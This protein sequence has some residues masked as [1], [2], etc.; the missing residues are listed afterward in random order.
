MNDGLLSRLQIIILAAGFSSRLGEPKALARVHATSLLRRALTIAA[1]LN[2]SRIL[3]IV[4]RNAAR[5]RIEAGGLN[6]DFSINPHPQQGLSSS[7][8]RGVA[9]AR[10][11]AAIF[12]LPVDLVNL[13]RRDVA[14][15]IS[16]WRGA[17]RCVIARRVALHGGSPLILPRWLFARALGLTG[18][19]G[20]RDLT[21]RLPRDVV[22]LADLPSAQL[23]IDTQ[24]DLRSARRR[25]RPRG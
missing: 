6:V 13:R 16:R 5:Y 9:K 22:R 7:V 3:A 11:A 18:D 8:R 17:R 19:V 1:S 4:P 14:R 23:D 24:Q 2:S 20:L 10:Y 21:D 12:F 15:L 25:L